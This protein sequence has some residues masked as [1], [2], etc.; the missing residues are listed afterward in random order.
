[1]FSDWSENVSATSKRNTLQ[2]LK[3]FN[4]EIVLGSFYLSFL[5]VKEDFLQKWFYTARISLQTSFE[6][7]SSSY[8]FLPL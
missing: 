1:M 7:F 3:N 5:F 8:W 2:H 4:T 6:K